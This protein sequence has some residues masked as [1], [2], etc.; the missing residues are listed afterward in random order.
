MPRLGSPLH[1]HLSAF[2]D[3]SPDDRQLIDS[4]IGR[5]VRTLPAH[6]DIIREGDN[7]RVVNLLLEG[8]AM[9]YKQLPDGRRQILSFF[10]PGDLC[11]A[12]VFILGQMDHSIGAITPIRYAEIS[13]PDFETMMSASP[14]VT[15]ALWW[16]ELVTTAIQREWTTNIG[17]RSAY[18]RIAHLF[19]EIIVRLRTI[20]AVSDGSCDLP[21][22]QAEIGDATG[23][24]VVHVN[25]TLQRLR[26]DGLIELSGRKLYVPD[27]ERLREVAMFNPNYLH[28]KRR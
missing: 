15:K 3:L 4:L 12:H 11:D 1:L 17:Q 25:R 24:T 14:V 7:P 21:L 8:W 2:V 19:C 13:Q 23:L 22:T 6:A 28:L 9:R 10:I 18:E 5:N 27:F 20:D 16:S 26:Q